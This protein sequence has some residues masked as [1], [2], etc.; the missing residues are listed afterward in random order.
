MLFVPSADRVVFQLLQDAHRA[1]QTSSVEFY[2]A[3]PL[4]K[5]GIC[6]ALWPG[7]CRQSRTC[8]ILS[9]VSLARCRFDLEIQYYQQHAITS[10]LAINSTLLIH[11]ILD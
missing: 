7:S 8:L 6:I 5:L 9:L 3:R 11:C 10:V 4:T 1:V 2:I